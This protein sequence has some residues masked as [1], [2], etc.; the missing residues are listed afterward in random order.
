MRSAQRWPPPHASAALWTDS[1]AYRTSSLS[2]SALAMLARLRV[3]ATTP[4][5]ERS[6]SAVF[7]ALRF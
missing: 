3:V 5:C 7:A 1:V 2:I 4:R 6:A